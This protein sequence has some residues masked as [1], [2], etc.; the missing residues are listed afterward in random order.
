MIILWDWE[1]GK[2]KF[3][4]HTGHRDNVFQ[5]RFM[6]Y[7]NDRTIVTSAAD[8]EVR[9]IQML[10]S[11]EVSTTMLAKHEG[12]ANKLAIEP[13]SPHIFYSCGE[14]GLVQHF[15]LRTRSATKIITCIHFRGKSVD[16]PTVRLNAITIDP[17]NP[18]L[19]A[20]AGA[21][22]YVRLYDIRKYKCG[23]SSD[24]DHLTDCFCPPH[25]IGDEQVGI[26]GLAFSDQSELLASYNDESIYL[27][28]K[29]QGLGPCPAFSSR[30]SAMVAKIRD[31]SSSDTGSPSRSMDARSVPQVYK[32]H[33]NIETVKGVSFFG[34]NC[35]YVVSG[36]DC[37]RVFIWRK[38]DGQLLRVMEGDKHVVNCIEP[39]PY[40]TTF[41]S[42]GIENDIKIWIPN[43]M[44]RAPP[45][46]MDELRKP[47]P[48]VN[49]CRFAFPE[50]L[51]ARLVERRR[52]N[53]GL[54]GNAEE[55]EGRAD[56]LQLIMNY[57]EDF[58][59]RE[60]DSEGDASESPGDCIV[61]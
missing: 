39:H 40:A 18:N 45:V 32:G 51:V 46:N 21:E 52:Q 57:R 43:T 20:T 2:V 37:G 44:E 5:A 58:V 13:G 41:A 33:L 16:K 38:K 15:D 48:R 4:F 59:P 47:R 9:H 29:D 25:L 3:L 27:F 1:F 11:G 10:E 24:F 12:W 8:G 49:F 50:D 31:D 42:S 26:T 14:D 55:S 56:L 54:E 6:P 53:S 30:G 7:T 22:E 60:D 19:I 35:E 61:S 34:P 28:S 17:R 36:S 23:G